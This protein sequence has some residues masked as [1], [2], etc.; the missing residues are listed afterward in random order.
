MHSKED[1]EN[2][3]ADLGK[4][5]LDPKVVVGE[6][7]VFGLSLDV[8][9]PVSGEV[10][11]A[12]RPHRRDVGESGVLL[13]ADQVFAHVASARVGKLHADRAAG[14]VPPPTPEQVAAAKKAD[15]DK[16]AAEKAAAEKVAAEKAAAAKA[17]A[18]K[19]PA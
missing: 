5:D 6:P 9:D 15:D 8:Y 14:I 10:I 12:A 11:T 18:E 19:V 7:E 17:A 4:L 13:T 2:L 1:V 3:A 16:A